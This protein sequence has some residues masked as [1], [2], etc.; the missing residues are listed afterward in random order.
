MNLIKRY[1]GKEFMLEFPIYIRDPLVV[2]ISVLRHV[3]NIYLITCLAQNIEEL[4]HFY[5][6]YLY[7]Y[8]LYS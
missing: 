1:L 6:S 4:Q 5:P 7:S 2:Q 8:F 3:D